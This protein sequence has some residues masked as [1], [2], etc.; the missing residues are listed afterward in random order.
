MKYKVS[1]EIEISAM[2]EI[3]IE[4]ESESHAYA[5]ALT[6]AINDELDFSELSEIDLN[7][8]KVT[9]VDPIEGDSS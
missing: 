5:E 3:D 6:M 9:L 7:E 2:A 4:A 1:L 8:A